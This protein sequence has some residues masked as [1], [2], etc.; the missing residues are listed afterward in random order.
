MTTAT[1]RPFVAD[2]ADALVGAIRPL[3]SVVVAFSG[4]VDSA[5]VCQAAYLALGPR[6]RAVT[7]VSDS[8]AG[9][10]R[11]ETVAIARRIGIDHAFVETREFARPEYTANPTNRC[12]YCKTELYTRLEELMASTTEAVL[13][14]GANLDDTGDYRPGMQAAREHRVRSPLIE[15]G[16]DKAGVRELAKH[17]GLPVWDKPASP[18]L[19]SRIAYGIEVTPERTRRI[20]AAETFLKS[21]LGVRELRVRLE[22][23]EL[24]R[25]EVPIAALPRLA[26]EERAAIVAEL[27]RLGFR[28]VT[29]DL[30]GFRSG[31]L[32]DLVTLSHPQRKA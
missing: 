24:A 27:R 4:G 19:S 13:L 15:L 9:G 18:C 2:L 1:A 25:I 6:A 28:R 7:A 20:D 30:E 11:E 3:E 16:I 5:V 10:E 31:S 23:Q 21:L 14:N 12:Y 17:W 26:G 8:L 22:A 29:I 32:N